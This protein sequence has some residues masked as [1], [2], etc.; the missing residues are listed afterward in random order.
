MRISTKFIETGMRLARPIYGRNGETL[1][2]RGTTL[3]TQYIMSL[4]RHGI[5]TVNIDSGF[6]E[7]LSDALEDMVRCSV[8][9]KVQHEIMVNK[10]RISI[11]NI[12]NQVEMLID[13]II[14][15][16]KVIGNLTEICSTDMYTYAHSVDVCTL[17]L[18][19]GI[20]LNYK[21]D[22]LLQLGTGCLLHDL[23]KTKVLPEILNKPGVLDSAEFS[24]IKKH[25]LY[26][27]K[28]LLDNN[29]DIDP[30]S[31]NIVLDHHEKYDGSGYPRGLKG[32]EISEMS[33]ICAIADVYNA[34][35]TD[36]IYRRAMPPHEVYE[37]IMASGNMMF[38]QSVVEAF[39]KCIVPYNIGS[40]VR[41]SNGFVGRVCRLNPSLPLRPIIK[42]LD[43]REEIDLVQEKSIVITGLLQ[44]ED[45]IKEGIDRALEKLGSFKFR[46]DFTAIW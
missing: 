38:E 19:L 34:I 44:H 37:M 9:K 15:G 13:E 46:Q 23:G 6:E 3:T 29:E 11:Q 43:S 10:N 20:R 2:N 30:E 36:R 18:M 1:L 39:L 40:I 35:T 21:K 27:Y 33:V 17:S 12:T 8:M 22:K 42:L 24:E 41:L 25:P 7:D 4:R 32:Q 26:G 31:A 28:M 45:I 16:K 14:S 5:L